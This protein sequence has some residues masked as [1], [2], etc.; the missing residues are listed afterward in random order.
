M[1]KRNQPMASHYDVVI[2][3]AGLAGL[4]LARQL[5]LTTDKNILL[6][7][8]RSQ[9]PPPRQKVGEATVQLGGYYFSKVL[10]LEEHL[11]R[12][13]FM[14]YNLRFFWKSAERGNRAYEDYSQSFIKPF[15]NIASYQLD[16]N[17]LETELL[18]LN[19]ADDTFTFAAASRDLDVSLCDDGPHTVA[20]TQ[21]GKQSRVTA[22]WVVDTAGRNKVLARQLGLERRSPIR[23]GSYFG[24]VDGLVNVEK[25]TARTPREVRINKDRAAIGHLPVWLATNHFVGEGFWL[26]VIPLQGKTSLGVVFDS[27][28]LPREKVSSPEKLMAWICEEFPLFDRDLPQRRMYDF[29]GF[30]SFAYDCA[31][32]IHPS[33]WALS[34]EA[35]R[36]SDPLYSPGG[37]LIAIHNTLIADAIADGD[38][39][40]SSKCQLYEQ[41]LRAVYQ[42]YVPSYT[43]S[44]HTLGDQEIFS[45]RYTW[46]LTIYFAGYVFPFINDFFT[47]RRFLLA[48]IRLF[49]QLGPVNRSVQSLLG[50]YY[51]WKQ[52][53]CKPAESP[54][55]FDFAESGF[56]QQAEKTFYQVGVEVAEAKRILGHQVENLMELARF[57]GAHVASAVLD[58]PRVVTNRRYVESLDLQDLAFDPEE[59]RRRWQECRDDEEPYL[60]SFDPFVM[61]RFRVAP[62]AAADAAQPTEAMAA[63]GTR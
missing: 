6:L 27:E 43:V 47:N 53:N 57:V 19:Q 36:F 56:L 3:G 18:R 51:R 15:S 46:E 2:V 34:G 55:F 26:W 61:D 41:V 12:E 22:E 39:D 33:K 1:T 45:L 49:S 20:F 23:H 58:D 28:K 25:L 9:V 52:E 59:M 42:A 54:I 38:A 4:S 37:D 40:I 24:W 44:Y 35:G 32:T 10:D 14:K 11:L 16:R 21:E 13:H 31:E 5:L 17:K 63:G 8:R 50:D 7:E 60:W 30:T 62:R 48:F 29:A